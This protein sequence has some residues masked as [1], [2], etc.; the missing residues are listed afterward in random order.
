MTLLFADSEVRNI[1]SATVPLARVSSM[2]DFYPP[3][4]TLIH[5]AILTVCAGLLQLQRRHAAVR[6]LVP[7]KRRIRQVLK[8]VVQELKTRNFRGAFCMTKL[9]FGKHLESLRTDPQQNKVQ[10][11]S[12]CAGGAHREIRLAPIMRTLPNASY[13]HVMLLFGRKRSA[14]YAT[15]HVA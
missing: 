11:N 13:L 9:P 3:A 6:S 7:S 1:Q 10:A 4:G 12:S 2:P 5:T 15:F 8:D 14:V